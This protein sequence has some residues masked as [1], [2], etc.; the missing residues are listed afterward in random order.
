MKE[1]SSCPAVPS[2]SWLI[3]SSGKLSFG[4]TLFK[5]EQ[6]TQ[7]CH[8]PFDFLPSI[9][10]DTYSGYV[11]SWIKP[12]ADSLSTSFFSAADRSGSRLRLFCLTK[13]NLGS[14]LSVWH[15]ISDD[16]PH[17]S[18]CIRANTFRFMQKNLINSYCILI[19]SCDPIFKI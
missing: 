6:S 14:I 4:Q 8:F 16:I 12:L 5:S 11:A 15:A 19:P 18:K 10:F 17:I 3:L 1:S 13:V 9:G 2:T 7:V